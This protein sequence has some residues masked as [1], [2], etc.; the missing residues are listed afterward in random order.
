MEN[1]YFLI[2][3]QLENE[4]KTIVS[5]LGSE[6]WETWDLDGL[7]FVVWAYVIYACRPNFRAGKHAQVLGLEPGTFL[8]FSFVFLD[9]TEIFSTGIRA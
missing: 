8:M 4:E 6:T 1:V 7:V 2:K 5:V 9:I 3:N